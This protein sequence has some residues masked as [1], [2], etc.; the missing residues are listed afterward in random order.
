M[1]E[2]EDSSLLPKTTETRLEIHSY[3]TIIQDVETGTIVISKTE[4]KAWLWTSNSYAWSLATLVLLL[5]TFSALEYTLLKLSLPAMNPEDKDGIKFPR[6]LE[7]LRRLN[8]ILSLYID[9]YFLNV[10]FTFVITYIYLQSFSIPGSMWLSILGGTLFSFW[11]TLFTVSLCSAIGA[12][13]A[14]IISASLGSVAVIKLIGERIEKWNQQ[15]VQHKQ[16]M[17]NYMIVLRIS[18]F[19]PNWI[20][21]LGS[22]QLGVPI[23]VFFWGTFL[24]VAPPSFIHVQAGAALDRL[25]SSDKLELLTLTNA[26]CLFAVAIVALIPVFLKKRFNS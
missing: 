2:T 4:K 21:N 17:F 24:G 3:T 10:Y 20:V 1:S 16:H 11:L 7:E 5:L 13:I 25:S 18:P 26:A 15:L 9:Q 23:G 14:Y 22:P 8:A 12:T 19:P 6:N